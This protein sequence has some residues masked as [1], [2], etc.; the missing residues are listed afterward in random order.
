MQ[1][2][3]LRWNIFVSFVQTYTLCILLSLYSKCPEN[4][5]CLRAGDNPNYGFTN[6]DNFGWSMLCAFRLMT[7]DYWENL[8]QLVRWSVSAQK[9]FIASS[10]FHFSYTSLYYTSFTSFIHH[11]T[12]F[13][14]RFTMFTSLF[15]IHSV[16]IFG[17]I[18]VI[19]HYNTWLKLAQ[20]AIIFTK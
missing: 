6:F 11:Y 7:Q 5:M 12:S 14:N 19:F 3:A 20:M 8:Y 13:E 15:F 17:T 10:L 9:L 2:L 16:A 4:C 1:T 18:F